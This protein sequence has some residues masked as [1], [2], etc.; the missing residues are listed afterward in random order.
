MSA[1]LAQIQAEHGYRGN[2]VEIGVYHGK[3]LTGL[4]TTLLDGEKAIA[5]D[6]FDDQSKNADLV[7]Y[8]EVGSSGIHDLTQQAFLDNAKRY[9]PNADI[10]VIQRS[11]LEV[12]PED[13]LSHG[14]KVRFFS[15]D[16]GHTL[17]VLL[18]DLHLA[19]ATLAPH[20]IIS[21]DDILNPQWPGI[22][23]GVVRF[24]DGET[25]LR[26][27]AFVSNKLL[28]AFE[29]FANFYR[30]ALLDIAPQAIQRRDVEFSNYTADQYQDGDEYDRFLA[31]ING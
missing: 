21:I 26:P 2:I 7:G 29:P 24:F 20:G 16:G 14:D 23:T 22:I 9:C 11:S 27:V 19:V 4:A 31:S 6:V 17:D 15:I 5:I 13:I 28:C 3:Y 30:K 25:N 10:A 18:N 12:R 8:D 1:G